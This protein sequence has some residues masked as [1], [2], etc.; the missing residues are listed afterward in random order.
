MA[1]YIDLDSVWRDRQSYSN[2]LNYQLTADQISSWTRNPK[3]VRSPHAVSERSVG[4]PST[5][6][7]KNVTLPYPRVELFAPRSIY[8]TSTDVGTLTTT[9]PHLLAVDDVVSTSSPIFTDI[10]IYPNIDYYVVATPD[11]YTFTISTQLG[12]TTVVFPIHTTIGI[13]LSVLPIASF[14]VIKDKL[15]EAVQLLSFP[16]IYLD[17]HCLHQNDPRA[18]RTIGGILSDAK[19]VLVQDKI[20][21]DKSLTPI[22]ITYVTQG[23][24]IMRFKRDEILNITFLTRSGVIIDFFD[25]K[26]L[27]IVTNPMVQSLITLRVT[28]Y[29][30]DGHYNQF[31]M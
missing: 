15:F 25:E 31:E 6:M 13:S 5:V 8:I 7:V 12:G 27:T 20:L 17:V 14:S 23:D 19:Y 10:N 9:D 4:V 30:R 28:P 26:D 1:T 29:D 24:Q 2:P 18:I 11:A 16:R 21:L 22:W 3:E